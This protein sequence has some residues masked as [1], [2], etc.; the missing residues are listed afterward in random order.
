MGV[1]RGT[2]IFDDR[3]AMDVRTEFEAELAQGASAY[4]AALAV[5]QTRAGSVHDPDDGPAIFYALA[6]LQLDHG[7]IS[8]MIR[9]RALTLIN[10][11][12]GLERWKVETAEVFEARRRTEQEL[13][14]RLVAMG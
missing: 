13:R 3:L 2:G 14:A 11:G 9:K 12:E 8:P 10:S 6:T 1:R 5:L 4:A 7:V